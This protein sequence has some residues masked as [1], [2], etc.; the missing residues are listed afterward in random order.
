MIFNYLTIKFITT[1]AALL[2]MAFANSAHALVGDK[3]SVNTNCETGCCRYGLCYAKD[4]CTQDMESDDMKEAA[5]LFK[6][7]FNFAKME[8]P[9][10]AKNSSNDLAGHSSAL[11][12]RYTPTLG[13]SRSG[14]FDWS[15]LLILLGV[16]LVAVCCCF[17]YHRRKRN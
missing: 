9:L 16:L 5:S 8:A 7:V 11:Q 12:L 17:L 1:A 15:D 2:L 6:R 14:G 3:Y 10:N 4:S 13:H